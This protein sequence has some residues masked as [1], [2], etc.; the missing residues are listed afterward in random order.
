VH[1]KFHKHLDT[2]NCFVCIR[3]LDCCRHSYDEVYHHHSRSSIRSC[4]QVCQGKVSLGVCT[5]DVC[6]PSLCSIAI[7]LS[8][9]IFY[10]T[11]AYLTSLC[12]QPSSSVSDA[13]FTVL[14]QSLIMSPLLWLTHMKLP[15]LLCVHEHC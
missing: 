4:S 2:N 3:I 12:H 5:I 8:W 11:V 7:P 13:I 9:G 6:F 15:S 1:T 10:L 14:S